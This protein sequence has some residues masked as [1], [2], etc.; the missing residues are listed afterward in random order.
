MCW[1]AVCGVDGP[2]LQW[3]SAVPAHLP[4]PTV[5]AGASPVFPHH[6]RQGF[7][8]ATLSGENSESSA[9]RTQV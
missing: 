2:G 1:K 8:T 6:G 3:T 5:S 4:A 7:V 9:S